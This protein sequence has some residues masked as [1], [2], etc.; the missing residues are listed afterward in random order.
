MQMQVLF[1]LAPTN[2]GKPL[3]GSD[4]DN[5]DCPETTQVWNGCVLF[6]LLFRGG[7]GVFGVFF[8]LRAQSLDASEV[9]RIK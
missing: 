4:K 8:L 3:A 5:T 7:V 9:T 2:A 6:L 1:S